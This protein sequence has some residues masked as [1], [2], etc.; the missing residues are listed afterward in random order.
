MDLSTNIEWEFKTLWVYGDSFACEP[1]QWAKILSDKLGYYKII[2]HGWAGSS[3][4]RTSVR[5]SDTY[6]LWQSEDVVV[7]CLTEVNREWTTTLTVNETNRPVRK[8]NTALRNH[9]IYSL[10]YLKDI[11]NLRALVVLDGFKDSSKA[12]RSVTMPANL[13]YS[14]K[15]SLM[16][17]A[18]GEIKDSGNQPAFQAQSPVGVDPREN[19]LSPV[20]HE[21][22]AD[23]VLS[24]I[25]LGARYQTIDLSEGFQRKIFDI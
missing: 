8:L 6:S 16:E 19:H 5:L 9:M 24:A 2:N 17:V 14:N 12:N 4:E 7:V 25:E 13:I 20:N 10:S 22:L 15:G 1:S 21:I 18:Q 11:S 3:L 23:K